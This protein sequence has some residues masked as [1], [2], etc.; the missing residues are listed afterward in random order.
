MNLDFTY[1]TNNYSCP[2]RYTCKRNLQNYRKEE[3][4]QVINT[5]VFKH[6]IKGCENYIKINKEEK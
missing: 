6:D 5:S 2:I 4:E 3:L 1:C